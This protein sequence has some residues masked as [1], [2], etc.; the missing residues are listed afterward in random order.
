[1]ADRHRLGGALKGPRPSHCDAPDLGEDQEAV[2]QPR[3]S[4]LSDLGI[5]EARVL[6]PA[7]KAGIARRRTGL[8]PAKERLKGTL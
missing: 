1:M 7:L 5:G 8:D 4:V 2:V 6:P 3:T